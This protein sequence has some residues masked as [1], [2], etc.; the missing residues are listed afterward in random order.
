MR[1]IK[2]CSHNVDGI[3]NKKTNLEV[4]KWLNEINA[5]LPNCKKHNLMKIQKE[6]IGI[7]WHYCKKRESSDRYN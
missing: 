7:E 6:T 1:N 2:F 5:T 3:H 4:C